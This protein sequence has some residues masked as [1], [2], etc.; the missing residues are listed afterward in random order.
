MNG[1]GGWPCWLINQ[2]YVGPGD[3]PEMDMEIRMV[4]SDTRVRKAMS[5]ALDRDR[6]IDVVWEGIGVPQQGTISPQAWHFQSEE[7]QAVFAEW[8]QADAQYDP[9]QANAWLDEAGLVDAD[10]DG[11]RDLPSG[12]PFQLILDLGD[13]GGQVVAT[14][15]TEVFRGFL[16]AVGFNVLVNNLIGQPD[17]DLRQKEGLYMLRNCHASEVDLWTYPDWVFPLRNER[18]WPMT[19]KWRMTGGAE[20][21]EPAPDSPAARLL[22]LYDQ[23]LSEPDEQRRHELVWEAIRIHIEEGPFVLGAAGDQPMPAVVKN[24]FHNVPETGILGPWA[25]A[26]PG[27]KH[28]EQFY[29]DG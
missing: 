28:P 6:L 3:D 22:A 1:A 5:V 26:S 8:Q 15:S 2:E 4:L 17:W 12:K 20:G 11:F 29:I 19:G 18:A 10:G 24:N 21:E 25:P 9:D 23:G 7:G 16:E 14:E 27:N 13:W